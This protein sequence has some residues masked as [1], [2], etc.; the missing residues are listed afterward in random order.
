MFYRLRAFLAKDYRAE[1][2]GGQ[3]FCIVVLSSR[4]FGGS[5]L[6]FLP[7]SR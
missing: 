1:A 3:L 5:S 6:N 2:W 4:H 7:G